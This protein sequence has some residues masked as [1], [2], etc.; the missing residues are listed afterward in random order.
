MTPNKAISAADVAM[1]KDQKLREYKYNQYV[2]E[3]TPPANL[4]VNILNA[5]WV[6][7]SICTFGQFLT[8]IYMNFGASQ[9]LASSY[10]I[11][12]LIF[13]SALFTG[14]NLYGKI[15]NFAGAG[16]VVPITGFANSVAACAIE[17]K[18]EGHVFG[19]GCQI[20]NIAG[21]V[22]LYGTFS[23]WILGLIYYILKIIGVV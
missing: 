4:A 5:F 13:L 18:K 6:G 17:Y 8:N 23:S 12:T 11:L 14:L 10:T 7:G 3:M 21:P 19:I 1:E 20:F 22:I 9:Q 15:T 2:K 16:T